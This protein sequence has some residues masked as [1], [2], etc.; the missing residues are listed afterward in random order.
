MPVNTYFASL[1]R[2]VLLKV[3]MRDPLIPGVVLCQISGWKTALLHALD[4][5][6][7]LQSSLVSGRPDFWVITPRLAARMIL[8]VN[9]MLSL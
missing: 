2:K 6:L 7:L 3:G 5:L 4:Q 1:K 8:N 9:I